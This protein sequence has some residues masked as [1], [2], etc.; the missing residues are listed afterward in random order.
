MIPKWKSFKFLKKSTHTFFQREYRKSLGY[1]VRMPA[2]NDK[3]PSDFPDLQS[4]PEKEKENSVTATEST[5]NRPEHN[6]KPKLYFTCLNFTPPYLPSLCVFDRS[7][8]ILNVVIQDKGH[9]FQP[10]KYDLQARRGK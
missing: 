5:D 2:L 4:P 8:C 6:F 3:K 10:V 7:L 1:P 9:S